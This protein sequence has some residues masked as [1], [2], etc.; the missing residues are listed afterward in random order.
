MKTPSVDA[1]IGAL[2][3]PDRAAA[4]V[5]KAGFD[6]NEERF[7]QLVD[8]VTDYAI[9]MLTEDGAIASWNAGAE[10]INGYRAEQVLGK[11]RSLP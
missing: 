10:R 9:F 3:D 8:S 5:A 4:Q 6:T 11:H 2:G 1:A 7:R